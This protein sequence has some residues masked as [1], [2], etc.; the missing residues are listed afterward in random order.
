MAYVRTAIALTA[1][2]FALIKLIDDQWLAI[3]G[4]LLLPVTAI[5]LLIGFF[6]YHRVR[7]SINAEK[8]DGGL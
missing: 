8:H 7:K 4:W 3:I 1:S 6:D 5:V 2:S